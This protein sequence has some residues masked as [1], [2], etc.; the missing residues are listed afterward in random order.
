MKS[1]LNTVFEK[2]KINKD[3]KQ[4][5]IQGLPEVVQIVYNNIEERYKILD[6]CSMIDNDKQLEL[7]IKLYD[8]NED[9]KHWYQDSFDKSDYKKEYSNGTLCAVYAKNLD[10]DSKESI[11]IWPTELH[12]ENKPYWQT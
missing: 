1:L 10:K 6:C 4:F 8:H 12:A 7:F 5:K 3:S 9:F 2:L 11:Y